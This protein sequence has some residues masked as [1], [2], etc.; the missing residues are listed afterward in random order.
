MIVSVDCAARRTIDRI[1]LCNAVR[2]Q[3]ENGWTCLG[4]MQMNGSA[5]ISRLEVA[6]LWILSAN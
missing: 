6:V 1:L 3:M 2:I 5:A 4:S